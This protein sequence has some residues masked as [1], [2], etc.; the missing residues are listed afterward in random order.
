[1]KN[2]ITTLLIIFLVE[3]SFRKKKKKKEFSFLPNKRVVIC[4]LSHLPGK[5]G[6]TLESQLWCY[7][8]GPPGTQW[9]I[10]S[11]LHFPFAAK[12][13]FNA[14]CRYF[15][16]NGSMNGISYHLAGCMMGERQ[17]KIDVP[18]V[19]KSHPVVIGLW[20]LKK[21]KYLNKVFP[22]RLG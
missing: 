3:F 16:G 17:M 7:S 21:H 11:P 14:K 8:A 18:H 20:P 5:S 9:E 19:T 12:F 1:M 4:W 22:S 13:S 2:V 15:C 10:C 6:G